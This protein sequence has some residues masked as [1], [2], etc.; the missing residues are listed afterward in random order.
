MPSPTTDKKAKAAKVHKA[1]PIQTITNMIEKMKAIN[2]YVFIVAKFVFAV[3]GGGGG[4]FEFDIFLKTPI[5]ILSRIS[6]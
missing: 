2:M 6:R 3:G 4:I 1:A 5:N